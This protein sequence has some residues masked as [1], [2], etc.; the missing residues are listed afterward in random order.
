MDCLQEICFK[1]NKLGR[2]KV[3]GWKNMQQTNIYQK[4]A[5]LTV[6]T[7]DNISKKIII[8]DREGHYIV[9]KD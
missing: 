3:K 8:S 1:Y 6:L 5:R 2:L 7:S 4:E 9:I